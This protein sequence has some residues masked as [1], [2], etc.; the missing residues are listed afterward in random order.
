MPIYELVE[1]MPLDEL[2][3]WQLYL[4][5]EPRGDKRSDWHAAV[6]S[7]I[8]HDVGQSFSRSRHNIKVDAF[9][10]KFNNVKYADSGSASLKNL[11]KVLGGIIPKEDIKKAEVIELE[12]AREIGEMMLED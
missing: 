12:R 8:V 11:N 5:K 10:L 4:A 3:L 1:E 7:K 9:L 6:V 2:Q